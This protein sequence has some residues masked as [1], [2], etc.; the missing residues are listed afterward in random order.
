[1]S[2][3]CQK[4]SGLAEDVFLNGITMTKRTNAGN[5][6]LVAVKAMEIDLALLM[7][8]SQ[9]AYFKKSLCQGKM[10]R[11]QNEFNTL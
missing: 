5:L 10:K 11:N 4:T 9:F 2:V 3:E 1:M 7:N 6:R 8:A